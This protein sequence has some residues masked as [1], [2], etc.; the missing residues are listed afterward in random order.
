MRA[1]AS[2]VIGLATLAALALPACQSTQSRSAELSKE[3][4]KKLA[5]VKGLSIQKSSSAVKVGPTSVISD[6]NGTAVVVELRNTSQ[7]A[8]VNV[9][10]LIDVLDKNGKSVFRND[11]PGLDASLTAVPL[12]K[13]GETFDWV[14]DQVLAVRPAKSV[15]VK[16]GEAQDQL[17]GAVPELEISNT[18]LQ[19]DPVSGVEASGDVTNKSSIEQTRLVLYGV[20]RKGSKVVAAGRAVI[21][22]VKADGKPAPFHVFFIGD[23]RGAD[24]TVTAPPVVYK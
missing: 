24:L 16:V 7:Q 8:L 11:T 22:K 9:P 1:R 3:G 2:I 21:Q 14:N 4:H 13:P 19:V 6:Q 23:P 12:I 17:P 5:S 20:A 18:K 10:V 15:K